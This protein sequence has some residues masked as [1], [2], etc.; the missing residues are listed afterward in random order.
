MKHKEHI[1][2]EKLLIRYLQDTADTQSLQ[3]LL[4]IVRKS[5][6][7]KRELAELQSVY[8]SL[9]IRLDAQKYP[10]EA[11]WEKMRQKINVDKQPKVSRKSI[12]LLLSYAAIILLALSLGIQYLYYHNLRQPQEVADSYTRFVVEKGGGKSSLFLPDGTKV[13]LN[14]GTTIQY[15]TRFD[16]KERMVMLD[17]EGFFEVAENQQKP[18]VV[19]LKGHDV[20]VLGTVFNVKAYSDMDHTVT[21]LISGKVLL[22]SY[23]TEGSIREEQVLHPDET[24]RI[25]KQTGTITTFRSDDEFQLAWTKGLYKFKDKP[26]SDVMSELEHLYDVTILIEDDK[27]AKSVYTG[28]LVLKN[29]IEEVLKPLGQYN[30]FRYRK[31]GHVIRIYSEK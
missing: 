12:T 16:Q 11:S 9:S 19:R 5:E 8:D 13:L 14:A 27:L 6:D 1:D 15:P 18:F 2:Y 28:S 20:K 3:R 25:D 31:E 10:I 26:F 17:G 24:A 29:T 22:T 30:K 23:D 7:K 4:D 21:S